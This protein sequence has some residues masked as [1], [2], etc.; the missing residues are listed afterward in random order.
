MKDRRWLCLLLA[1]VQTAQIHAAAS[2]GGGEPQKYRMVDA[3]KRQ[4]LEANAVM[5]LRLDLVLEAGFGDP[6]TPH[7]G[8]EN[9]K[10]TRR[11][12][13]LAS[14]EKEAQAKLGKGIL[15]A[16]M[17]SANEE[18][19][20]KPHPN[21]L[22]QQ[23][24][25]SVIPSPVLLRVASPETLLSQRDSHPLHSVSVKR[26]SIPQ[27]S[28]A[29]KRSVLKKRRDGFAVG[30]DGYV[31]IF[32]KDALLPNASDVATVL[33]L[34]QM[35][36]NSY[37][38]PGNPAWVDIPPYNLSDRFGWSSDGIRGYVF[39]DDAR[40]LIVIALK[41]T[42]LTVPIVGGGPTAPRD[43]FNDNMMFSC[44]CG[45]V[46]SSWQP[47]CECADSGTSTCDMSCLYSATS[48]STSTVY[49]NLANTIYMAVRLWYPSSKSI[50]LTG[51]SLGGALASLVGLTHDLPV[52]AFE[53]PG[54]FMFATR[55]GLI[56]D[57]PPAPP[58]AAHSNGK[59]KQKKF[60][61][62]DNQ[63]K[64]Q[65]DDTSFGPGTENDADGSDL[66]SAASPSTD[67]PAHA[68]DGRNATIYSPVHGNVISDYSSYLE[69]LE[70]Y[71]IGNWKDPIYMGECLSSGSL[72]WI[73][74]YALESKCH[75]GRECVYE[76]F[77]PDKDM[78]YHSIDKVIEV[79]IGAQDTVPECRVKTGC[80]ECGGW[81]WKV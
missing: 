3:G 49:Y 59:T 43:K 73:A 46:S 52:F 21:P 74:G 48:F 50:W 62:V 56:P 32:H 78:R 35:T 22:S 81:T 67:I 75:S 44:C 37:T 11:D 7:A 4:S 19:T 26:G 5:G 41:G 61:Q 24:A 68:Q 65:S 72:C 28:A 29:S 15:A 8:P 66:I 63:L 36:S 6:K 16:W 9:S 14:L 77:G 58:T 17:D 30:S 31:N 71:H 80:D 55:I 69:T 64:L 12:G 34:A 1:I 76:G 60:A 45:K 25:H 2:V 47:V 70:I 38:E 79:F 10:A 51:H 33:A 54:D 42:S 53:A 23:H 39:T 40:D 20:S 57:L 18:H 13:S 27:W